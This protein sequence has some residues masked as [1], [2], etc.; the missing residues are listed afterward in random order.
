[1]AENAAHI[2]HAR[3]TMYLAYVDEGFTEAEALVL[4][5]RMMLD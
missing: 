3:R 2:A 1:M 4:C 5:Q